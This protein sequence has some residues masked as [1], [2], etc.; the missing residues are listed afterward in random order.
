MSKVVL[1]CGGRNY[2]DWARLTAVLDSLDTEDAPITKIVNGAARG[3]DKMSTGWALG[4]GTD[5]VEY[6]ADWKQY[7]KA[8]GA[9]R[10]QKM[11]DSEAIDLVVSFPG[12]NG[13]ADMVKRALK[14]GIPVID[15]ETALLV[16]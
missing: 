6:P 5:F 11:L 4:N 10:N 12:G 2:Q 16:S 3:A 15:S 13:T 7:G 9:I 8:A 1:V 14:R